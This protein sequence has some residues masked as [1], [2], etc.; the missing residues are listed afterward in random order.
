[1]V[2]LG[3]LLREVNKSVCNLYERVKAARQARG[4]RER[5]EFVR[6]LVERI[7]CTCEHRYVHDDPTAAREMPC[8]PERFRDRDYL[9]PEHAPRSA[10]EQ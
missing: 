10:P 9:R 3:R 4:N 8:L 7:E 6:G 2:D 5:A 1:M